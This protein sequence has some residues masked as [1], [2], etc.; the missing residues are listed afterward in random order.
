[1][2]IT[3]L[4]TT[5]ITPAPLFWVIPLAL[6]L[7]S[8]TL[9][10]ARRPLLSHT[11]MLRLQPV[12]VIAVAILVFLGFSDN[13]MVLIP[14]HLLAFFVTAMVCHGE[15]ARTRPPVRHLTEFYLWVSVGG[16][17]GGI[18]NVLVAPVLFPRILEYPVGLAMGCLLRPAP[19]VERTRAGR[20]LDW[21]LPAA[22]AAALF[23]LTR[24]EFYRSPTVDHRFLLTA[25]FVSLVC[26]FF[27][28][29][30]LRLG[31]G[32]GAALLLG[33]LNEHY[34]ARVLLVKRT[35]FGIYTVRESLDDGGYHSLT[36]GTTVHGAQNLAHPREPLTYYNRGGPLGHLFAALPPKPGRRVAVVGLGTGTTA[37]Y[38]AP[39]ERWTYYEIDP[40]VVRIARDPRYFTYL[41][42]SPAQ[43]G[44]VLGDARLS[45]ARAPEHGYD[46]IVLDAFSSDAIPVHLMTREALRTYLAKLA[47]GGI[48]A[49]HLSNR[50]LALEPVV[51]ALVRD[52]GVAGRLGESLDPGGRYGSASTWAVV[53][54]RESDLASVLRDPHWRPL[55]VR[56]GMA[57]WTDDFSDLWSVLRP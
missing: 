4:I 1:L 16:T 29:W 27:S 30:P 52:A 12:L 20:T 6:Y 43:I 44:V 17:L 8:F 2:S 31:L 35:F 19:R 36:H 55:P 47:P 28:P 21:A 5:D 10:F 46:L 7:L 26:V 50:F 39:G 22:F 49:F 23:A 18:F 53:A 13:A 45:L 54:R 51:G 37:A 56:P 24:T 3:T 48:I 38:G 25:G 40:A 14:V 41:R 42:D 57:P 32:V 33:T 9:T 15:L 11:R 34:D